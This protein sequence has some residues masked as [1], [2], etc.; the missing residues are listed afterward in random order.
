MEMQEQQRKFLIVA[1]SQ[2]EEIASELC[3]HFHLQDIT[4][5]NKAYHEESDYACIDSYGNATAI[6]KVPYCRHI[7]EGRK[8]K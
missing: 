7:T 4:S 1:A 2:K 8:G 5:V 6:N 3:R